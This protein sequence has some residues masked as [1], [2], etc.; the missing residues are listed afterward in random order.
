MQYLVL[1]WQTHVHLSVI[2]ATEFIADIPEVEYCFS[3]I[4]GL[5]I[6]LTIIINKN[7]KIRLQCF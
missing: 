7:G 3:L 5:T 2:L 6:S 1:L 4:D